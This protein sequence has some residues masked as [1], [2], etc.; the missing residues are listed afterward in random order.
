M[1]AEFSESKEGEKNYCTSVSTIYHLTADKSYKIKHSPLPK[2]TYVCI[3][4]LQGKGVV[5]FLGKKI[6][7]VNGDVFLFQ[8]D[9]PFSYYSA[10]KIWEFWWF[11]FT[12]DILP[13]N[14]NKI[15]NIEYDNFL[16]TLCEKILALHLQ[17]DYNVASALFTS[18]IAYTAHLLLGLESSDHRRQILF[19][20]QI[21]I[22]KNL[23]DVT[24]E[25]LASSLGIST[26]T[27]NYIYN[28]Y[29][30]LSPKKYIILQKIEKAKYLLRTTNKTV[31]DIALSLGFSS[32][33]HF[34]KCFKEKTKICPSDYRKKIVIGLSEEIN[35]ITEKN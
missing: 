30:R 28:N 32:S 15:F 12:A 27:L 35:E 23:K 22:R 6:T 8:G 26:R 14:V 10:D 34:T 24:V 7:I 5:E 9:V 21:H 25:N 16:L 20:S 29:I 17:E 33:F 18:F 19:L 11:E 4:S 2:D 13:L 1:N 3:Y 31:E